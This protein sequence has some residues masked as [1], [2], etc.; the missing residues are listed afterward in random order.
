MRVVDGKRITKVKLLPFPVLL[1]TSFTN[2]GR[3]ESINIGHLVTK[4]VK[5]PTKTYDYVKTLF[6]IAGKLLFDICK[7]DM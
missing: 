1:G 4:Q 2:C 5:R 3:L 6:D 7:I